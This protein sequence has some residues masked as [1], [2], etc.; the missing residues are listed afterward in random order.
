MSAV[1]FGAIREAIDAGAATLATAVDPEQREAERAAALEPFGPEGPWRYAPQSE[2]EKTVEAV[3][4]RQM[5]RAGRALFT[6]E[7]ALQDST[8][9]VE[10]AIEAAQEAPGPLEAFTRW[11][12]SRGMSRDE[13]FGALTL[14][15]LQRARFDREY[16]AAAP[17]VVLRDYRAALADPHAPERSTFVAYVDG[18]MRAGWNWPTEAAKSDAEVK[19]VGD[20]QRV[21]ATTREARIPTE[22]VKAREAIRQARR[23]VDL[24]KRHKVRS[25]RVF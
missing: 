21:I 25:V 19:A 20:L 14:A 6:L 15:E 17:S 10:A 7:L 5:D 11:S 3:N 22:A 18:R 2:R 13:Q 16:A 9:Q 23:V 8:A 1:D 12:G 24:A 4:A